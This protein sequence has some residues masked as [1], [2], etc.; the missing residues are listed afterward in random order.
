[1]G[2]V[3]EYEQEIFLTA[4]RRAALAWLVAI[5]ALFVSL[6]SVVA[7]AL[8]VPL[9]TTEPYIITVNEET[10]LTQRLFAVE[11]SALTDEE[12]IIKANI[13]RYVIDR[14]TYDRFDNADR[15][16]SVMMR[17]EG[18]ARETLDAYWNDPGEN[19]QHP[20]NVYGAGVR[21]LAKITDISYTPGNPTALVF[22]TRERVQR[23]Q[24]T[25]KDRSIATVAFV[26]KPEDIR[27]AEDA[28]NNPL[29]FHVTGYRLDRQATEN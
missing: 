7:V 21:V 22:L 20:D 9:K 27:T 6:A 14:E 19:P 28:W 23:N 26:F 18:S 10:G 13:F 11:A 4:R 24:P 2:Q 12:A 16:R 5:L 3:T 15:I 1:M 29:G 25:I 17:S 8:L